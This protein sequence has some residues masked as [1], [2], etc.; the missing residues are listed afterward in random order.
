N[1]PYTFQIAAG[2]VKDIQGVGLTGFS[3]TIIVNTIPPHLT[4]T[5]VEEGDIDPAGNLTYVTKFQE[6]IVPSSVSDSSFDLHGNYR[7]ADY[8]PSSFSFDS[9]DMILT[10]NYTGLPQDNYTLTLFAPGFQDRAGYIL[11]GEPHTPRPPSV[12]TG[13]GVEGGNFF[14]DFTLRH[15]TEALPVNFSSVPPMGDLI[16]QDSFTD[17]IAAPPGGTN[18]YTVN[19]AANQTLTL[20]LTSDGSLQGTITVYDPANSAIASATAA[21]PGSEVVLQTVPIVGGGTYTIVV[22]GAG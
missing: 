11:D 14:V 19:L 1:I 4:A 9:T 18:T 21:A 13:N 20:D 5:S 3:E 22:G 12:P 6:P 2:T 10:I 15:G 7:N 8:S 17:V 16:Y